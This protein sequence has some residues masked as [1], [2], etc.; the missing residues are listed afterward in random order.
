MTIANL[1]L[2]G[3]VAIVTGSGRENG[4]GSGIAKTLARNGAAVTINYVSDSSKTRAEAVAESIRKEG[5]KAT[6]VRADVTNPAQAKKLVDETLKAFQ[7][8]HLDILVNNAGWS[9]SHN[10]KTVT[11]ENAA[12]ILNI[13]ILGPIILTQVAVPHMREGGRIINITSVTS[14]LGLPFFPV[15]SASKAALDSLTFSWSH[16]FGRSKGLTVNSIGPGPVDTEFPLD[17]ETKSQVGP[18]VL[19]MTRAAERIG[20]VDDIADAVLLVVSEKARWITGQFIGV[21]GGITGA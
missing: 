17:E 20:T 11:P 16:E 5:G 10:T 9:D 19:S 7:V 15:Y 13:N 14:K 6:V 1:S 3:K 4:I 21:S 2:D 18:I 12:K 8:D